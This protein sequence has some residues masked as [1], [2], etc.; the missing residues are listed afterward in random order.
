M[1]IS[2]LYTSLYSW[3][4]WSE[5]LKTKDNYLIHVLLSCLKKKFFLLF[6]LECT[7]SKTAPHRHC[8]PAG[9][10]RPHTWDQKWE[11]RALRAPPHGVRLLWAGV[12]VQ[13]IFSDQPHSWTGLHCWHLVEPGFSI[14]VFTYKGSA[15]SW[16]QQDLTGEE[17]ALQKY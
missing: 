10:R 7:K 5:W 14:L 6:K 12:L 3:S 16:N 17:L 15:T 1:R 11:K 9:V 8:F 2:I 13:I 4:V